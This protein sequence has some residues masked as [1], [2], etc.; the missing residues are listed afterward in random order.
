MDALPPSSREGTQRTC[1]FCAHAV[2]ITA[3][4]CARCGAAMEVQTGDPLLDR[5]RALFGLDL[6]IEREI[7]RG[8]QAA[9]YS[10][11][12]PALQRHAAVKVALF[13]G[14]SDSAEAER[15]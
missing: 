7:G 10:A 4:F 11:F 8:A 6:E 14:E 1:R 9:V 5:V 12:D 2:P 15:F 3:T 13:D